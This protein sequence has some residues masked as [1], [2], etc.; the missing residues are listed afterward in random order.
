[1][2]FAETNRG[3]VYVFRPFTT[4]LSKWSLQQRLFYHNDTV[5]ITTYQAEVYMDHI[6]TL[7]ATT[8]G[9]DITISYIFKTSASG[10]SQQ[11]AISPCDPALVMTGV[12]NQ[13]PAYDGLSCVNWSNPQIVGGN[14]YHTCKSCVYF[15]VILYIICCIFLCAQQSPRQEHPS[16]KF[17]PSTATLAAC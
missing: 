11:Q 2:I 14:L 15:A 3:T 1:M 8:T 5:N 9:P 16:C 17:V 12:T 10:W 6:D 7:I 4:D 13:V